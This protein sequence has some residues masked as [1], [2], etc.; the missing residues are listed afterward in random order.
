VSEFLRQIGPLR[1]LHGLFIIVLAVS[2]PFAGGEAA[3]SGLA[4]WPTLI[5]PALVP[6]FVFVLPLDMTMAAVARS[7]A[8]EEER[9][10]LGRVLKLDTFLFVLLLAAW[11]PFFGQ[12]L[13]A[14]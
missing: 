9:F 2:A 12:L 14:R 4:M 5:A 7:G 6:I 13:A 8:E 1:V 11:L 10:R 3:Y